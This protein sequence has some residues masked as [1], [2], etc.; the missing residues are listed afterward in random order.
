MY[1]VKNY[2]SFTFQSIQAQSS[3]NVLATDEVDAWAQL[4]VKLGSRMLT[5]GF[6]LSG[7]PLFHGPLP[8]HVTPRDQSTT[9]IFT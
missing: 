4:G 3:L 8:G 2:Y 7:E 9:V 6:Q 5:H 1:S